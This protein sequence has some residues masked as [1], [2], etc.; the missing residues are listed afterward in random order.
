[1][2]DQSRNCSQHII[3]KTASTENKERILMAVKEKKEITY[4]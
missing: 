1:M 2:L 4:K 3:I